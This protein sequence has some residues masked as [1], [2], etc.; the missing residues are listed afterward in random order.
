MNL[1]VNQM[2]LFTTCDVRLHIAVHAQADEQVEVHY[3]VTAQD[4][5][6]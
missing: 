5:R 3:Q 4:I 1:A 6:S 2:P